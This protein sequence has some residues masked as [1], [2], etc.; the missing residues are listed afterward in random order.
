M[1]YE[2]IEIEKST[3]TEGKEQDETQNEQG[4]GEITRNG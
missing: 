2:Q 3:A 1:R 4:K